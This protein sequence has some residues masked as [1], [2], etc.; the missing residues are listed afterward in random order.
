VRALVAL[1]ALL[2]HS[3]CTLSFTLMSGT[4]ARGGGGRGRGGR[5][6]SNFGGRGRGDG[7]GATPGR[8]GTSTAGQVG[9]SVHSVAEGKRIA[10]SKK[11]EAFRDDL[12]STELVFPADL[13]ST[14]H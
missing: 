5:D 10:L 7:R 6:N 11:L 13:V 14:C 8:G 2:V 12:Q 3:T 4:P 9:L 1:G